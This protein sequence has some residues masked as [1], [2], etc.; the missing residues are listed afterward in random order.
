MVGE[1]GERE[2][3]RR[4][5]DEFGVLLVFVFRSLIVVLRISFLGY[6][7][8][9]FL[10]FFFLFLFMGGWMSSLFSDVYIYLCV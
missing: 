6:I 7:F 4:W 8:L 3:V 2:K 1:S 5:C 10:H 9:P